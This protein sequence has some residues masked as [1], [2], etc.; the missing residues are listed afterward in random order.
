MAYTFPDDSNHYLGLRNTHGLAAL[1]HGIQAAYGFYLTNTA[2]K[3]R[4]YYT[5]T[6]RIRYGTNGKAESDDVVGTYRLGNLVSTFPALSMLNHLWA[7]F[8]TDTYAS[9]VEK[10]YNPVRWAE[11]SVSA[12]L[13]F[14]VIAQMSGITDI[15][16]LVTMGIANAGLQA[17]GYTIERDVGE[18][19]Y[20]SAM[21]QEIPGFLIFIG[22]WSALF[23]SFF[24]ALGKAS[25]D[26][27][28]MVYAII[29]ILFV[30]MAVFG[31]LSVMHIRK[32]KSRDW[33]FDRVERYYL[34]LSFISKSLLTNMTLFGVLGRDSPDKEEEEAAK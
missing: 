23:T 5:I 7:Y 6:N 28:D 9:Y 4:G 25:H 2:F 30:L 24:S 20:D 32:V 29:I 17:L 21:R 1:A 15:K 26:V 10:G 22:L 13:M 27:P 34:Y 11:Y 33:K 3:D 18:K 12:G 16:L 19:H 31:V 8:D 14:I